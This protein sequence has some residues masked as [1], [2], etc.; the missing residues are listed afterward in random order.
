M[1]FMQKSRKVVQVNTNIKA[2][3]VSLPKPTY[4]L[5][6]LDDD[7]D[8]DDDDVF[9]TSIIDRYAARPNIIANMSLAGFNPVT[10]R[11]YGNDGLDCDNNIWEPNRGN[12][13]VADVTSRTTVNVR[14]YPKQQAIELTDG[15]GH[16][17]KR[18]KQAIL[19]TR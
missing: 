11:K 12:C 10:F 15:L 14:T 2:E 9:A 8:D 13:D 7:D 1:W 19:R 18:K 4:K 6:E 16:M 3:C 17:H 5:S